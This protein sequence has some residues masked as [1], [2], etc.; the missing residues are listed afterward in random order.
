MTSTKP[1][2]F[3]VHGAWHSA[4][5]FVPL[6]SLFKQA[7]YPVICPTQPTYNCQPPTKTLYDD[8]TFT[9]SILTDLIE[10]EQKEV[11]M[12]MHSYGGV[13]GTE[14]VTEEL[15]TEVR[16]AKGLKGGVVRLLYMT[17][18]VLPL[19]DS[20]VTTLGGTLP[21]IIKVEVRL[22]QSEPRRSS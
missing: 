19:G 4:A 20:L 16:Q 3:I 6:I 12:I 1:T 22:S 11:I 8:A 15:A 18:F 10:K 13:V 14:A 21:P 7:G 17:A 2:I 5:H 9:R